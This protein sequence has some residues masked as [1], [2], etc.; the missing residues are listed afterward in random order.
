MTIISNAP[1]VVRWPACA[2][3]VGVSNLIVGAVLGM[4]Y[5]L[6]SFGFNWVAIQ[7][8]GNPGQVL[9]SIVV[10]AVFGFVFPTALSLLML[11]PRFGRTRRWPV[12]IAVGP[13]FSSLLSF[14]FVW[15]FP[16]V[17]AFVGVAAIAGSLL[18]IV[19]VRLVNGVAPVA[20]TA[21]TRAS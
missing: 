10:S 2:V 1:Y 18:G 21:D 17:F 15:S 4:M 13:M 3:A 6:Y 9:N 12:S 5:G 19:A 16:I 11:I 7:A 20:S 8:D 14:V